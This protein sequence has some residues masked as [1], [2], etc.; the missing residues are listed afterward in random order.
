LKKLLAG[1]AFLGALISSWPTSTVAQSVAAK[2]EL[3]VWG[4]GFPNRK[5]PK[6]LEAH[7]RNTN[8][9]ET[10]DTGNPISNVNVFNT[11]NRAKDLPDVS[12]RGLLPAGSDVTIFKHDTMIDQQMRPLKNTTTRLYSSS[13]ECYADVVIVDNYAIYP[14]TRKRQ[15]RVLDEVTAAV[16]LGSDR[17]ITSFWM[18]RF[19]GD[20]ITRQALSKKFDSPM[21]YAQPNTEQNSQAVGQASE[22]NL[23]QFATFVSSKKW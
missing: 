10:F 22:K 19:D 18:Q 23:M 1:L 4:A 13:S 21:V 20:N 17:F 3:H 9:P 15:N 11:V 8:P 16:I 2:C 12:L 5:L 6:R 14:S 7:L